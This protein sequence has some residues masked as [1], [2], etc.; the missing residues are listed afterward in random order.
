MFIGNLCAP[1]IVYILFSL[2]QI[3]I[4]IYKGIFY[5][6]FMK[7][8]VMIVI[9]A[10][11]NILCDMGLHIIAW[12]LVFIP[13]IMM[14]IVSTLLLRVFGTDPDS[15][16]LK[17][18]VE[19]VEI[20]S[21]NLENNN[22]LIQQQN[23]IMRRRMNSV[24]RIDR[25][26]IR[27]DF[28]DD[29]SNYYTL[30]EHENDKY[31]LSNNPI[32]Y[33]LSNY[34]LNFLSENMFTKHITKFIHQQTILNNMQSGN[35]NGL[36]GTRI[37]TPN[38]QH[39]VNKMI[40]NMNINDYA[41]IRED[42]MNGGTEESYDDY[43]ENRLLTGGNAY[44]LDGY[45]EFKQSVLQETRNTTREE[46]PDLTTEEIKLK[47]D[48]II[49]RKWGNKSKEEKKIW[50]DRFKNKDN[51]IDKLEY[52]SDNVFTHRVRSSGYQPY[53]KRNNNSISSFEACP[54]SQERNCFGICVRSCGASQ[55]GFSR[56]RKNAKC[57]KISDMGC[58]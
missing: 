31:D 40:N 39:D 53:S 18:N 19:E 1:S 37:N 29:V 45:D 12:F 43:M 38:S 41:D 52:D 3:I 44:A 15:E 49:A 32:K 36:N 21:N 34:L 35:Q 2:I 22:L 26:E 8:V 20:D 48:K 5:N 46:Y 54:P 17:E 47:A 42:H 9:A 6:A 30:V 23:E 57:E 55:P 13:I 10:V 24:E 56:R 28:Y 14:T 11:V 4:D 7:F 50:N 51:N 16:L 27:K 33:T 58:P 25:D